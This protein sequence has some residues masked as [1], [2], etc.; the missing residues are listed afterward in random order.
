MRAITLTAALLLAGPAI[1]Q[2]PAPVWQYFLTPPNS[3]EYVNATSDGLCQ[4]ATAPVQTWF[5]GFDAGNTNTLTFNNSNTPYCTWNRVRVIP[6][7][8]T[9]NTTYALA[10]GRRDIATVGCNA[11]AGVMGTQTST[12]GWSRFYLPYMSTDPYKDLVGPLSVPASGSATCV[13]GCSAKNGSIVSAWSSPT[14]TAQG[15]YRLSVTIVYTH[16]SPPQACSVDAASPNNPNSPPKACDGYAG[17]VN[18]KPTCVPAPGLAPL[19]GTPPVP[20]LF[21]NPKAGG[22][23]ALPISD[24][25]VSPPAG[26][27]GAGGGP[28]SPKDGTPGTA[29]GTGGTSGGTGTGSTGGTAT[30]GGTGTPSDPYRAKDPCGIPGSPA[31]KIDET[32]TGTGA[33]AFGPAKTLMDNAVNTANNQISTSGSSVT[34]LGWNWAFTLPPSVCTPFSWG[35]NAAYSVN[36]C[37]N[38]YIALFR[39]AMG[40]LFFGL[41]G[42]Y[43]WRSATAAPSGAK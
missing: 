11:K 9:Q 6:G 17:L 4:D 19:T 29:G 26:N 31:C 38:P 37:T 36:P 30:S 5:N 40:F 14:P 22:N 13:N 35:K 27:G 10:Y 2:T 39:N 3:V 32:G 18:G 28:P 42:L 43:I 15:L 1:A 25:A 7:Q 8:P 33:G 23:G 21:G 41:A 34:G 12:I 20:P 24:P 16:D